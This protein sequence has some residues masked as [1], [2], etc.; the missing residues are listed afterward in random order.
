MSHPTFRI[1]V[2]ASSHTK[3]NR[4]LKKWNYTHLLPCS[5]SILEAFGEFGGLSF[6]I[7]LKL[8]NVA[9]TAFHNL[10]STMLFL[11][12]SWVCPSSNFCPN[13]NSQCPGRSTLLPPLLL[14]CS[15]TWSALLCQPILLSSSAQPEPAFPG[16]VYWTPR[17]WWRCLS[18]ASPEILSISLS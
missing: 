18:S 7:K 16:S 12:I 11:L 5:K 1:T 3:A 2:L 6:W 13:R 10:A 9:L 8:L 17:C 15:L 4:A 14:S